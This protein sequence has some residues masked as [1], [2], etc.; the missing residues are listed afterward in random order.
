[1]W[2]KQFKAIYKNAFKVCASDPFYLVISLASVILMVLAASMPSLGEEEHLRL[3]R[4]QTHSILFICGALAGAFG[5][6]RVVTD[7]LRRGAGS[8]LMSRPINP[9]IL[10][11]GKLFG[12][13]ICVGVLFL[14]GSFAYLWV[15]EIAK[16]NEELDTLS[17]ILYLVAIILSVVAGAIRQY[18]FGSNFS[19]CSSLSLCAL[20]LIGVGIRLTI[21]ETRWFDFQGLQS[22]LLLF[23]AVASFCATVQVVA[24]LADSAMVLGTAIILF[25]FGLISSYLT[26]K[27][28]GG[29]FGQLISSILP[30]WQNYWILEALGQG[31]KIPL[32]YFLQITFQTAIY[33]GMY[34]VIST[35]LF[36]RTEIK[37]NA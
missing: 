21:T 17:L 1:M 4:D 5:L 19:L 32:Q 7:D 18:L 12:V 15:S 36:E 28:L 9:A 25:F 22:I 6:I 8:I 37:G 2:P 33:V 24:V 10:M 11:A 14:T 26:T 20:M 16:N 23:L 3:V 27:F 31:E 35:A 34:T 30:N 13:L 29:D